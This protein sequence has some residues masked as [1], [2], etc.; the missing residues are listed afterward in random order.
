M[1]PPPV[2]ELPL[3][4]WDNRTQRPEYPGPQ[5]DDAQETSPIVL[6]IA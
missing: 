5:P 6:L 2:G 3:V 4:G 1:N